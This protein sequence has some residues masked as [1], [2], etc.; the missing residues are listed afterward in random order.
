VIRPLESEHRWAAG[1]TTGEAYNGKTILSNGGGQYAGNLAEAVFARALDRRGIPFKHVAQSCWSHDFEIHE[2][3]IDVKAKQRTVKALPRYS[4]H[5]TEGQMHY[6]CHYYVFASVLMR[7]G[8]AD[9]VEFMGWMPKRQFW[10]QC[11]RVRAGDSV[12]GL[13]EKVGAG[14]I[15]YG[16]LLPMV[17]LMERLNLYSYRYAFKEA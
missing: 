13:V 10:R 9:G 8:R 17:D 2:A 14:R 4:A 6:D 12:D 1:E 7:G 16:D 11:A 15:E 3:R 5:V